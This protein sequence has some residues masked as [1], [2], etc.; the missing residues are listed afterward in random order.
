MEAVILRDGRSAL[1]RTLPLPAPLAGAAVTAPLPGPLAPL[2][3]TLLAQAPEP[4]RT[5][6]A[7]GR[8]TVFAVVHE[9]EPARRGPAPAAAVTAA[10]AEPEP[11]P[12]TVVLGVALSAAPAAAGAAAA[13]EVAVPG[14][15]AVHVPP[16]S[17]GLGVA[18]LLVERACAEAHRA[19]VET[20]EI[21]VPAGEDAALDVLRRSGLLRAETPVAGGVAAT[22]ATVPDAAGA[23]RLDERSRVATV[24]S[25]AP[26]LRP[27]AVAVVG[28]SRRA[29]SVGRTVVERL[30]GS[31]F[32]GPVFPVNPRA[33][34]VAGIPA[35]PTLAAVP[36]PIDLVVIAVPA[37]AV[38]GAV[39]E[40]AR[41][42]ARALVILSAGFAETGAA[43]R[44]AQDAL[45]Q[46]VRGHGMRMVGPNC[47]GVFNTHPTVRLN[48]TFGRE[49]PAA[50]HVA[51]SSQSGA[52]GLAIT[53]Y[54]RQLGLGLSSFV[55][56]G[57][58]ADVSSNDLLEYWEADP[59]TRVIA[60]YMESFGNPRRFSRIARRV[61]RG[62]PIIAVKS[63]RS[64]A[65]SR[66]AASHT[67]ALAGSDVAVDAL[68][69]Q[70]G[71]VRVDTL[72][73]L[74]AVAAVLANQP[75][76]AG[77][78]VG[79]LTNA[80][81][82]G[83][84]AADACAAAGLEIP[85]LAETT[86]EVL[87]AVLPPT[88]GLNNPVDMIAS[89]TPEQY[90]LVAQQLLLD[91]GVDALL[92]INI[93]VGGTPAEAYGAAIRR[94]RDHAALAGVEKPLVACFMSPGEPPAALRAAPGAAADAATGAPT[95]A[96]TPEASG[97]TIPTFR[98]PEEAA[99]A[100]GR[101]WEH[102]R[103]RQRDP[104]RAVRPGGVSAA[105][106][107]AAIA[108]ADDAGAAA[109]AR[110]STEPAAGWLDPEATRALLAACG[111]ALP[112]AE[113]VTTA[114]EVAAAAAAIGGPVAVKVVAEAIV[115]KSDVGGVALDLPDPAAAT[116][117]A[118]EMQR[119]IAQPLE[120]FLVQEMVPPGIEALVGVVHDPTFGPLIG[121]GL[122]GTAVEV[123]RDTTFRLAPLTDVDAREMVRAIRGFP[124]LS[125]YRGAAPVDLDALED[126]LLRV[127]WLVETLPRIAEMDL[128]PVRLF[129]AGRGLAVVD[130]RVRLAPAA[131]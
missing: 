121:F 34:A 49:L 106:G 99:H 2:L 7:A 93:S 97:A 74:F 81:G 128:N 31:A 79:I 45:V 91:P 55:S 51:M 71:I 61:A 73:E 59:D 39:E 108:A 114:A 102:A 115:H 87:R 40:A 4:L 130:T 69:R 19:G 21:V 37:A 112:R 27:A 78:R 5:A 62:K 88:A 67:A 42:G 54:A 77:N 127:S 14:R 116:A 65:G 80:G 75:L 32:E 124:L 111:I 82:P 123:L 25:L 3:A 13:T 53:D 89:A 68:F 98:F 30:V 64:A 85:A 1:L 20:V 11:E 44:G 110:S 63:G 58:K 84:L 18:T 70:S 9:Q 28:A 109:T 86:T 104:G 90:E 94:A 52:M 56:V 36:G 29:G 57:N 101:T 120:G 107:R 47:I 92:A 129:P 16:S 113:R 26:L 48:A 117:A 24:A 8:A 66:A 95:D 10:T 17:T 60:L 15:V 103:W 41:A 22:L 126:L 23:E 118:R 72:G 96:P 131:R 35:W 76:P 50:G 46:L 100:L 125:G 122:G 83:I 43:G 119:R 6:A 12:G 105:A 38:P 33:R